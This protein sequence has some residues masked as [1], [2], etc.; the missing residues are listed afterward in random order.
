MLK[1]AIK[2]RV[3]ILLIVAI[4]LSL[5]VVFSINNVD[6][7]PKQ[8]KKIK[9]KILFNTDDIWGNNDSESNIDHEDK[10]E[11]ILVKWWKFFWN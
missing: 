3:L 7:N 9:K 1:F 8:E 2:H 6:F 11:N 5:I 4:L 10:R